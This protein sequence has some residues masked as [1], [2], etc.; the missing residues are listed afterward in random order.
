MAAVKVSDLKHRVRFELNLPVNVVGGP[1]HLDDFDEDITTW[2]SLKKYSGSRGLEYGE[3]VED[4]R[5]EMVV[6]YRTALFNVLHNEQ[7]K[8]IRIF[9][10]DNRK[11][12]IATWEKLEEEQVWIKFILNETR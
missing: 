6:R 10:E 8:K 4:N 1:G 12:A 11:F 5:Y 9:I 7:V 3:I 2:G